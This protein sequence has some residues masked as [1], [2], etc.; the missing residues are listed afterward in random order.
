MIMTEIFLIWVIWVIL[1]IKSISDL[2]I[3]RMNVEE[4]NVIEEE[5]TTTQVFH[6]YI[7]DDLRTQR[8]DQADLQDNQIKFEIQEFDG[9]FQVDSFID[10]IY[11]VE[12]ISEYKE[13]TKERKVKLV[14]VKLKGYVSLCWES[15]RE[16]EREREVSWSTSP[17]QSWKKMKRGIKWLFLRDPY[18]HDNYM[19]INNLWKSELIVED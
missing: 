10:W 7:D 4:I 13:F 18:M 19:R 14:A 3:W 1:L 9:R 2:V 5:I 6:K 11:T 16:R 15:L 12:R 8:W 17:I